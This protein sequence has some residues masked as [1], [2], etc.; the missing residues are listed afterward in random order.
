MAPFTRRLQIQSVTQRLHEWAVAVDHAVLICDEG[1]AAAV[2]HALQNN[3]VVPLVKLSRGTHS[4]LRERLVVRY[5]VN[6]GGGG[7]KLIAANLA[8]AMSWSR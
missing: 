6:G 3:G 1:E 4:T 5:P 2:Q 7:R 8:A